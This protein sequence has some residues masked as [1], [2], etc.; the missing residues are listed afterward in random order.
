MKKN[1]QKPEP[2]TAGAMP[3]PRPPRRTAVGL[4]PD[5]D[6]DSGKD[7]KK[8]IAKINLPPKPSAAPTIEMPTILPEKS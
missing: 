3:P 4:G 5:D 2:K 1:H 7:G 6:D 8:K